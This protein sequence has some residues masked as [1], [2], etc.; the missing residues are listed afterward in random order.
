MIEITF[1]NKKKIRFSNIIII[2]KKK[3]EKF[4]KKVKIL[5]ILKMDI[6]LYKDKKLLKV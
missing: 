5:E 2:N 3:K 4:A 1:F 6:Y